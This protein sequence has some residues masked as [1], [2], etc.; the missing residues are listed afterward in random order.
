MLLLRFLPSVLVLIFLT[1]EVILFEVFTNISSEY[2]FGMEIVTKSFQ[3]TGK[4]EDK[5]SLSQKAYAQRCN[6]QRFCTHWFSSHEHTKTR[7]STGWISVGIINNY[8]E[9]NLHIHLSYFSVCH[10]KTDINR[11][12]SQSPRIK[13]HQKYPTRCNSVSFFHCTLMT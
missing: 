13:N 5:L 12:K 4:H 9:N 2:V 6:I 10:A 11:H 3:R 7:I 1:S 8:I